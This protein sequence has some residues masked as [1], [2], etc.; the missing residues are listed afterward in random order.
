MKFIKYPSDSEVDAILGTSEPL[1]MLVSFDGE[2][3][4]LSHLDEAVEYHILLTKA[5]LPQID[6]DK[7][8][9]I[10]FDLDGADWTFVCP[11]DYRNIPNKEK[12]IVEF[13][14][15]SCWEITKALGE[16]GY[17]IDLN[18]TKY[19]CRHLDRMK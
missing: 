14:K 5:G 15:D 9:R 3:A 4:V 1:M 13:Y 17:C 12:R 16:L 6:I 7:Y 10:I 8:F 11:P 19:Y 2:T 18:I